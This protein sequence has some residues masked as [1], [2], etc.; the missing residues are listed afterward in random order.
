VNASFPSLLKTTFRIL[1]IPPLNL[2]DAAASDLAGCFTNDRISALPA[3]PINPL[4]F[5]SSKQGTL[6]I[7]CLDRRWTIRTFSANSTGGDQ[8]TRIKRSAR[9]LAYPVSARADRH[10]FLLEAGSHE[11]VH[12]A[13]QPGHRLSGDAVDGDAGPVPGS[14]E[15]PAWIHF[16]TAAN[17]W[18]A[19]PARRRLPAHWLLFLLP[20][21]RAAA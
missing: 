3:L 17:R 11:A 18:W 16:I 13:Q 19:G 20:C 4:L 21:G 6:S 14:R 7:P 8:W 9:T 2:Y 15:F 12:M 10:R 1:G 5:D